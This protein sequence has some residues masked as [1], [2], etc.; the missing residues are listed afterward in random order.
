MYGIYNSDTLAQLIE[1]VHRMHNTT[2]WC[3]RTFAEKI[4]QWFDLYLHQDG[5]GHYAINSVL[6][7]TAIREKYIKMYER[8]WEQLKMYAKA[9]RI[10]LTGYL[11]ILLLP[12][13][14]LTGILSEVRNVIE[15]TNKHYN[16][17][18]SHLYHYYD[19]KLVTFGID[20][21]KNLFIQFPVFVQPY[22]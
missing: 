22:T 12:P 19:M 3:E 1:T 20:E 13:S 18:L 14:K 8:F 9:V 7:L 16:L 5:V 10:L 21:N 17:V 15:T 6:F 11:P 4:N 2:S